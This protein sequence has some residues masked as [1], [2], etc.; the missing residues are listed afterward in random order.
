L[1]AR[2]WKTFCVSADGERED[3]DNAEA[4]HGLLQFFFFFFF[5]SYL[6]VPTR[7]L[8]ALPAQAAARQYAMKKIIH[9]PAKVWAPDGDSRNQ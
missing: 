1:C 2:S 6:F 5:F 9:R 8:E 7:V 3:I 4:I